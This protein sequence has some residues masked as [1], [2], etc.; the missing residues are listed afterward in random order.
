L[1]RGLIQRCLQALQRLRDL[2]LQSRTGF[3]HTRSQQVYL[4]VD[5]SAERIQP[6]IDS[7]A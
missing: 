3:A 1:L 7:L 4:N 2:A 5:P 6:L